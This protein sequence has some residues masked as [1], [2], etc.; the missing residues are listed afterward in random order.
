MA[1]SLED[2]CW[3][4]TFIVFTIFQK[5][6]W[7]SWK[8]IIATNDSF[9]HLISFILCFS[10]LNEVFDFGILGVW[11]A[12]VPPFKNKNDQASKP[13]QFHLETIPEH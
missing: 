3:Y 6:I 11:L 12:L 9:L 8:R 10:P 7:R 13:K 4:D 1:T 5:V 2:I